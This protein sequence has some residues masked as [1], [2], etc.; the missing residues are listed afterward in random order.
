MPAQVPNHRPTHLDW[1]GLI[2]A[3]TEVVVNLVNGFDAFKYFEKLASRVA[4][5]T[6][7]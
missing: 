2:S 3:A 1:A 7:K 4:L 5:F 6:A